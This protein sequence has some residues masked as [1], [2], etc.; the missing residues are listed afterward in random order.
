MMMGD[1]LYLPSGVFGQRS[2]T[3]QSSAASTALPDFGG[4]H[5][6]GLLIASY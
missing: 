1:G 5:G 6:Q 2:N 4:S 3:Q